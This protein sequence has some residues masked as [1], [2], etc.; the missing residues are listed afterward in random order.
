MSGLLLERLETQA[1][2]A[3]PARRELLAGQGRLVIQA[4]WDPA[5][6]R[7]VGD[8]M[9]TRALKESRGTRGKEAILASKV[10]VVFPGCQVLPELLS[11]SQVFLG[12]MA[13]TVL[14]ETPE[15]G[16]RMVK[17]HS[18]GPQDVRGRPAQKATPGV[19]L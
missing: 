14:H 18:L 10:L 4:R 9:V 15:L 3:R 7:V 13:A 8:P 6:P 5:A 2:P 16:G 17:H 1:R 11:S 12:R 19:Q